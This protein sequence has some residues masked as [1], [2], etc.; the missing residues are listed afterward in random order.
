MQTEESPGNQVIV[1]FVGQVMLRLLASIFYFKNIT[2]VLTLMNVTWFERSFAQ[3]CR[4]MTLN[5]LGR[6]VASEKVSMEKNPCFR[7][8][9]LV[10]K[11]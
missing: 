2:C 1:T 9:R 6:M 3:P 11:Y 10:V 5:I 7:T 8:R 4:L